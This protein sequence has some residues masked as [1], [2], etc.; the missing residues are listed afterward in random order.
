MRVE[1]E[2]VEPKNKTPEILPAK[3]EP[4]QN[5]VVK[6]EAKPEEKSKNVEK[7]AKQE[8]KPAVSEPAPATISLQVDPIQPAATI[9]LA[10]DPFADH[11]RV[12]IDSQNNLSTS[13][14]NKFEG[15]ENYLDGTENVVNGHANVVNKG[16]FN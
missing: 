9:G 10:L 3:T 5:E 1:E 13:E 11:K 6:A 15:R 16:H 2:K 8:S 7:P 12:T 4:F 14:S